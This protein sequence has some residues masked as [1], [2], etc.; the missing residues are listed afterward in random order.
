MRFHLKSGVHFCQVGDRPIFLDL[1]ADRY[2]CLSDRAAAEFM[3]LIGTEDAG[4][5][6]LDPQSFLLRSGLIAPSSNGRI[7][8][9]RSLDVSQASALDGDSSPPSWRD[10]FTALTALAVAGTQLRTR[11]MAWSID[12]LARAKAA[13]S[14]D[15]MRS[16]DI[17]RRAQAL[18]W[19][20]RWA[21]S[22]DRCLPRSLA[23][24]RMLL[25]CGGDVDFVI[26]VRLRPFGA[27]SWAQSG[28]MIVN[29][30]Y[31]HVRNYTPIL[32]I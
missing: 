28:G 30:R 32:V 15:R 27:H 24:A 14:T 11:G 16:C 3:A 26:G 25:R 29:D 8:A 13:A 10:R 6:D 7:N 1:R 4:Q 22:H 17:A 2:F 19:T 21:R 23:A 9:C 5:S 31:D 20:A 12:A 18:A